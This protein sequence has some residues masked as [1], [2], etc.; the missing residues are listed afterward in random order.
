MR[1]DVS[2]TMTLTSPFVRLNKLCYYLSNICLHSSYTAFAL[3]FIPSFRIIKLV[4]ICLV[5]KATLGMEI[6]INS[7][8]EKIT[9]S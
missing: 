4:L 1:Y 8:L 5:I 9:V 7:R 6:R 2:V 3:I